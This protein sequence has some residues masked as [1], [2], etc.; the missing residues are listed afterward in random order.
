MSDKYYRLLLHKEKDAKLL[1]WLL[2]Q[3]K[4]LERPSAAI[5]RKL[6]ALKGDQ[7]KGGM[8]K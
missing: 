7:R 1:K 2:K 3:Q 8:L 4:P 5:K 6:Y